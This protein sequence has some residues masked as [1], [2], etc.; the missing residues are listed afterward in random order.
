[1]A[2]NRRMLSGEA[3]V[4]LSRREHPVIDHQSL[5]GGEPQLV[6]AGKVLRS[7]NTLLGP[8]ERLLGDAE[9]RN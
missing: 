5:Q 4:E 6:V 2:A 3:R 8:P 7:G 1:M 9:H